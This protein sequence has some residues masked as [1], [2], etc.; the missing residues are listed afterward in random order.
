MGKTPLEP[1][2]GLSVVLCYQQIPTGAGFLPST[3]L[4]HGDMQSMDILRIY[5]YHGIF[6]GSNGIW[7]PAMSTLVFSWSNLMEG[8]IQKLG[9]SQVQSKKMGGIDGFSLWGFYIHGSVYA[10]HVGSLT[11]VDTQNKLRKIMLINEPVPHKRFSSAVRLYR[12]CRLLVR[13]WCR[14]PH[15]KHWMATKRQ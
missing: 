14:W 5:V 12:M 13:S 2:Y 1:H 6:H 3:V 4:Q 11:R 15:A 9:W 7:V 8:L 10:R